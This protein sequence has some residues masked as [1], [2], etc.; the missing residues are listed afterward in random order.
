L[1]AG[2][3]SSVGGYGLLGRLAAGGQGVV[4][5]GQSSDGR[6]VAVKLLHPRWAASAGS[7]YTLQREADA[8]R[9][10]AAF[11]T[12]QLLDAQ[13]SVDPQYIVS[14]FVDGPTLSRAVAERGPLTGPSLD[15]LAIATATALVAIHGAGVIHRDLKPANI[16]LG[17]DGPRVI[18]FGI[19]RETS[20]AATQTGSL[21]G[22]PLYLAPEQFAGRPAEP[23]SD[24]FAWAATI[25]FAATGREIFSAPTLVAVAQRITAGE[26]D[27][28]GVPE[29]LGAVL[30][31]CLV[32]DPAQR[33]T[34]AQVL[35]SLIGAPTNE[36]VKAAD[37]L[38]AGTTVMGM[39]VTGPGTASPR[40]SDLAGADLAGADLAV[41]GSQPGRTFAAPT[42]AG[43]RSPAEA[44]GSGAAGPGASA[45]QGRRLSRPAVL[46]GGSLLMVTLA[47]AG[48]V[49]ASEGGGFG[50]AA[51]TTTV[52]V[53]PSDQVTAAVRTEQEPN[54]AG[55]T[56]TLP[57]SPVPGDGSAVEGTVAASIVVPDGLAGTW[58]GPMLQ[59]GLV[60]WTARLTLVSGSASGT[61]EDVRLGCRSGL[62]LTAQ[63]GETLTFEQRLLP[64]SPVLCAAGGTLTIAP[65]QP[66]MVATWVDVADPRNTATGTLH[67]V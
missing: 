8:A 23:A 51:P 40:V 28:D 44:R 7:R 16:L 37:A 36:P 38:A 67:R 52:T 46:A 42:L 48:I 14:E 4:Y 64:G 19:A 60:P 30:R 41:S 32:R 22:T 66:T 26:A 49:V 29:P 24:L 2:D 11:C 31:R 33:P 12:A 15:R 45:G 56:G 65:A 21:R 10:V 61:L 35:M 34:A 13:L 18:D 54:G 62:T 3:P 43:G 20:V 9:K 53:R 47:G 57:P 58:T 55:S 6:L 50:A 1:E 5:L 17:P 25:A 63:N 27:L 59:G 39:T